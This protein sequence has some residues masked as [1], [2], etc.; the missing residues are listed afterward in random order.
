MAIF[1]PP[2]DA[3]CIPGGTGNV[4]HGGASDNCASGSYAGAPVKVRQFLIPI[5]A[6]PTMQNIQITRENGRINQGG[7][8]VPIAAPGFCTSDSPLCLGV[9]IHS[10]TLMRM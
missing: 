1:V 6:Y 5:S 9:V 10:I 3:A 7:N 4:G 2:N 8:Y